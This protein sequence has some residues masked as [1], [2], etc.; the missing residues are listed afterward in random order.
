MAKNAIAILSDETTLKEFKTNALEVAQQF[1]I[2][3]ILPMYEAL[4]EEALQNANG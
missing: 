2:K 3:N 1:D 4:Y